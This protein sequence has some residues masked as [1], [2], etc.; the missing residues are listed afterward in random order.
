[1][2]EPE[3]D[4]IAV[5]GGF[6]G[7]TAAARAADLGLK[8]LVLERD[9]DDRY[10]C[11]SRITSGVFHVAS[12][13]VRLGA[14][15]LIAAIEIETAGYAKPELVRAIAENAGKTVEW[16]RAAGVKFEAR[17]V[18]Y[19]NMRQ[20]LVLAP[21]RRMRAGLDWEGRGGD[22]T[23]RV[24]EAH[25]A[26]SGGNVRRGAEV[27]GLIM[28]D[29]ACTGV[30]VIEGGAAREI[31]AA[32]LVIADG[33]FQ[34]N[35]G[36]LQGS[37]TGA[38]GRVRLRATPSGTGDG[39]RMAAEAGAALTE[40]GAFYGHL[41]A[42]EAMTNGALWPYPIMDIVAV[43]GVMVDGHGNR[44]AD[45]SQG[46]VF[47]SNAV[48]K[49]DDPLSAT[50]IM[51]RE[52]WDQVGAS[53]IAPPNPLL[54]DHGGTLI[55]AP[56]LGSLAASIEVPADALQATLADYNKAFAKDRLADLIP[57]RGEGRHE[58]YP[59][60]TGP[61][62]AIRVCAGVTNTMG[63]IDIDEN[64]RVLKPDGSAI[65]GLYAAGSCTGGLEGGPNVGYVGGLIKA[66]AFGLI[67]ADHAAAA[68]KG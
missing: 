61:Y 59:L 27:T 60:G 63:G 9:S 58:A 21:P 67:A 2:S 18:G 28:T 3:F 48:A 20:H 11:N 6:A 16:L 24:L 32:N 25:L 19:V 10:F 53:G 40:L 44:F 29:E 52:I 7:L 68:A 46:G 65:G 55:E 34:A 1:M 66:F 49:L 13:N 4:L 39:I 5:G 54:L 51:S 17:G 41:L 8:T 64:C 22:Y 14:D 12:N 57:V 35:A 62:C 30:S 15:E 33:G 56:D 50:V 36:M 43:A 23:L 42:A 26:K 38:P 45:E 37:V 31:S 47:L